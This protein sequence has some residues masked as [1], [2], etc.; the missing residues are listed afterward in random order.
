V[1][2]RCYAWDLELFSARAFVLLWAVLTVLVVG[3]AFLDLWLSP[4]L[5]EERSFSMQPDLSQVWEVRHWGGRLLRERAWALLVC[6]ALVLGGLAALVL[7][8]ARRWL[9]R[10]QSPRVS[11]HS[12]FSEGSA[13]SPPSA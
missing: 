10:R 5:W 7:H 8:G 2:G 11:R 3:Y 1:R 12:V 9:A 13:S 6:N 4:G